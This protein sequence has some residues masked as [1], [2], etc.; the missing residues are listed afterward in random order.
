MNKIKISSLNKLIILSIIILFSFLF[1]LSVPALYDYERLQNQLKLQLS[2]KFHLNIDVSK[3]IKYRILPSPHFELIDSKLYSNS[4]IEPQLIGELKNSKI[5]IEV[6]KIYSQ[7]KIKIKNVILSKSVFNFNKEN[8]NFLR[9]NIKKKKSEKKII[10][11][12]SKFFFKNKEETIVIFPINNLEIFYN[13]K[14]FSNIVNLNGLAFNSRFNFSLTKQ[15]NDDK[16]LLFN[17]KFP[18][19]NLSLKNS[20]EKIKNNEKHYKS[21]MTVNFLGSQ[22]KT[23]LNI[24]QNLLKFFSTNSKISNN[25]LKYSGSVNFKPFY[26]KSD[27]FIE[28]IELGKIFNN[29]YL[30]SNL[31]KSDFSI[32]K[33]FNSKISIK[34]DSFFKNKIFKSGTLNITTQNGEIKFD[35]TFFKLKDFGSVTFTDCTLFNFN[36]STI[37]KSKVTLN[38]NKS[39]KFYNAFQVPI[40]YRKDLKKIDFLIESNLSLNSTNI[41]N[42]K[43]DEKD[44]K[45]LS[46]RLNPIINNTEFRVLEN[47]SNWIEIKNFINELIKE[48]NLV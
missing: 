22:I 24:N 25:N 11:K 34:A 19:A 23:E 9:E 4:S 12:K 2:N 16:K 31:L 47:T 33:N 46:E 45:D 5:F 42:L 15:F 32:H 26:L 29:D 3:K 18:S 44:T 8:I 40:T 48:I 35:D 36:E 20:I 1:Y 28:K 37:F 30:I 43:I 21:L 17:L 41:S 13:K 7:K 27:I 38:I 39:K 14:N 6:N 10:V